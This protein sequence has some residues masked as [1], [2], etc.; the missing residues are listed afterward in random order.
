MYTH[1]DVKQLQ[2]NIFKV[3]LWGDRREDRESEFVLERVAATDFAGTCACTAD[4]DGLW[5]FSLNG[6]E[7]FREIT[8]DFTLGFGI[9]EGGFADDV[10]HKRISL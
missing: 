7:I 10:V 8:T 3:T 4:A 1:R 9:G 5:H 6:R 2:P